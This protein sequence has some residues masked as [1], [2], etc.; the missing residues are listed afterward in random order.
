MLEDLPGAFLAGQTAGRFP[1][2]TEVMQAG[3][4]CY[5]RRKKK[6]PVEILLV[7]SRRN[8]RWGIPKGHVEA[9]EVTAQT[10]LREAFEEAGV[11]GA[12]EE[13]VFGIFS[14]SKEGSQNRY[15]VHVH[16]LAVKDIAASFPEKAIRKLK[17]SPLETAIGEVS[18]PGLG[19]LLQDFLGRCAQAAPSPLPAVSA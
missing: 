8:G 18:Q 17:W 9:G 13:A 10:A 3:A 11:R 5:R 16:L 19:L 2:K 7:G 1:V 6:G 14:Y 12:A 15:H 4:I